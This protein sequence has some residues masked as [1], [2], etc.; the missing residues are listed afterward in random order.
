VFPDR[1]AANAKRKSGRRCRRKRSRLSSSLPKPDGDAVQFA[2]CLGHHRF[3]PGKEKLSMLRRIAV[4]SILGI[5]S[6]GALVFAKGEPSEKRQ[7]IFINST[8]TPN[9]P[10]I[11]IR[12]GDRVLLV[13]SLTVKGKDPDDS[14]LITVTADGKL[15]IPEA[16]WSGPRSPQQIEAL[17]DARALVLLYR[18]IKINSRQDPGPEFGAPPTGSP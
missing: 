13:P 3:E 15:K 2:A 12:I 17:H 18:P 5:G 6:I 11:Q 10:A 9:G 7:P 16:L 4:F 1:E 14:H 8:T